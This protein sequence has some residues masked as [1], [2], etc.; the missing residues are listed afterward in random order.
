MSNSGLRRPRLTLIGATVIFV[1]G[2]CR[3]TRELQPGKDTSGENAAGVSVAPK[4]IDSLQA[5]D[6]ARSGICFLDAARDPKGATPGEDYPEAKWIFFTAAGDSIEVFAESSVLVTNFGQ[7]HDVDG[8][9]ASS[10]HRRLVR[11]GVLEVEVAFDER[12]RGDSVPYAIR[13]RRLEA[14]TSAALRATGKYSYLTIGS[15]ADSEM[16]AVIPLA[17]MRS[18]SDVAAWRVDPG[19]YR[20][21]L[22]PDSLYVVCRKQCASA[23][24]I[25][26]TPGMHAKAVH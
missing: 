15:N 6:A 21:A 14:S 11:D 10:F 19:E 7:E 23:D 2:A 13:F 4:R 17:M 5:C 1:L 22:V 20:V 26:L 8:V 25:K 24:T 9:T 16:F 3:H 18:R 12:R